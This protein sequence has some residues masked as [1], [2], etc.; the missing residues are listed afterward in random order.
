MGQNL[1]TK[2]FVDSRM[3]SGSYI[4]NGT[5]QNIECGFKPKRVKIYSENNDYLIRKFDGQSLSHGM[6]RIASGGN[7]MHRGIKIDTGGIE[8][9]DTGFTVGSNISINT[10]GETYF[11]EAIA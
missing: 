6:G 4:G 9:T 5:E 10:N 1:A 11:W 8:I 3:P 7:R 2:N